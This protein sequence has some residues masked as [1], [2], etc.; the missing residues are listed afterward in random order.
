MKKLCQK[1]D[2]R[3]ARILAGQIAH[4][5]KIGQRNMEA[6]AAIGTRAQLMLSSHR[7]N[8]A[9]M[10]AIKVCYFIRFVDYECDFNDTKACCQYVGY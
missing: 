1:G 9:E 4:Y 7:T 3:N 5:R 6:S 2:V 10:E 8:R